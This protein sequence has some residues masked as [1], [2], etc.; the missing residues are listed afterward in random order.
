MPPGPRPLYLRG[1]AVLSSC[2]WRPFGEPMGRAC[3]HWRRGTRGMAASPAG[4]PAVQPVA[5]AAGGVVL[6]QQ[7]ER[8][9]LARDR[10]VRPDPIAVAVRRPVHRQRRADRQVDAAAARILRQLEL[11]PHGV[12]V[13]VRLA[14]QRR[15]LRGGREVRF[16]LRAELRRL[17]RAEPGQVAR[18]PA[19]CCGV[20]AAAARRALGRRLLLLLLLPEPGGSACCYWNG[21]GSSVTIRLKDAP[22]SWPRRGRR[23][24]A[25][26]RA[27]AAPRTARTSSPYGESQSAWLQL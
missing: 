12:V 21:Y 9:C 22:S 8:V 20:R 18:S 16:E 25:C 11:Q 13:V 1:G 6:D 7:R 24:A 26:R 27:A 4:V 3:Q 10:C 2:R 23:A 5:G 17:G 14:D 19:G 15:Q